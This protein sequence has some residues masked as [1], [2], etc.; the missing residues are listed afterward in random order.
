VLTCPS[1]AEAIEIASQHPTARIGTFE[2]R[3]FAQE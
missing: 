1:M 2:L 3:P